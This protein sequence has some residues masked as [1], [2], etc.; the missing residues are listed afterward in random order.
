MSL[1]TGNVTIKTSAGTYSTW[2]AFW[3]D[4]GNLTGDITCTVDASAFTES[5]APAAV[6]ESLNS[7]TLHVLPA[8]FPTKTDASTGARFTCNYVG[9]VLNMQMEG[10]GAVTIEGIV[11]IEGTSEPFRAYLFDSI[12]TEFNFIFRRNIIKGCGY[13]IAHYAF[14]MIANTKIYNNILFEQAY[15]GIDLAYD[16]P[17]AVI[18]NNTIVNS[19]RDGICSGDEEVTLEN[20]LVYNSTYSDYKYIGLL[21][22][23]NNN[24][25]SDATAENADWGGGGANNV[26]SI[27]DP[28]NNLASDDFTIT[29]EGDIGTAGKD[30]SAKFTDDFFGTTR[31]NWT[32]GACEYEIAAT[33]VSLTSNA[34]IEVGIT[35]KSPVD[36]SAEPSIEV[37]I[38]DKHPVSLSCDVSI[39]VNIYYPTHA[40]SLSC[41][42][43][44]EVGITDK[45]PVSL[46]SNAEIEVG[47]IDKLPASLSCEPLIEVTLTDKHPV[48]L[49]SE[50]EI[51][52]TVA[53]PTLG[54]AGESNSVL[55]TYASLNIDDENMGLITRF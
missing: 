2:A 23:G 5:T 25:D 38:T 31:V 9:V 54:G 3:D 53:S 36:I 42:T 43:E 49:T 4:L 21:T 51:S 13:G 8:T 28:F 30:L 48:S 12:S 33:P 44:N 19:A 40:V 24:A 10:A 35:D 14:T 46:T 6:T 1:T 7:H 27:S 37:G 15:G 55:S 11:I 45:L 29:A 18:A 17:D 32:I 47:I 22:I 16:I 26:N 41:E 50:A 52:V 39:D 20:N 34:E